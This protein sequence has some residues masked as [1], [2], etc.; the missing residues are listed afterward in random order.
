MGLVSFW[1]RNEYFVLFQFH[2]IFELADSLQDKQ[3][4]RIHNYPLNFLDLPYLFNQFYT[5]FYTKDLVNFLDHL[6]HLD[7]KDLMDLNL[8]YFYLLN[9]VFL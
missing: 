2:F 7:P 4:S 8:L 3:S 5:Q 6:N 9:L 1:S